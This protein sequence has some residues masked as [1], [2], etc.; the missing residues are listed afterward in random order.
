M[1]IVGVDI[2]DDKSIE[3][4]LTY[5]YGVGRS[6]S[7]Q[8]LEAVGV[9]F[10]AKPPQLTR[11]EKEKLKNVL[12][13]MTIEGRLRRQEKENIKRLKRINC[14]RGIRHKKGLPV[15][16]QT[17]QTNSRTVRDNV[18]NTVFSGKRSLTKT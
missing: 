6:L 5:I 1:R 16:G 18:R 8:I 17:T 7:S 4:A 2:P 9:D 11:Q 12:E 14:W 10:G 3:I 13:D 15:R